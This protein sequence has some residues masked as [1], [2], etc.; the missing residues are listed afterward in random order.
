MAETRAAV[1]RWRAGHE[2]AARRQRE[3]LAVEGARPEQAVA[4]AL[5]AINALDAVGQW[6]QP[7]DAVSEQ[8]VEVVR[9][10]WARIQTRARAAARSR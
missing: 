6:P 2:A 1:L 7:R 8:A 3:L 10:R 5:S 4:E 9:R